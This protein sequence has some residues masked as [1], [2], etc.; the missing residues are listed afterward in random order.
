MAATIE[1]LRLADAAPVTLAGAIAVWRR[2]DQERVPE[3]P[4]TP[5]AVYARQLTAPP[6]HFRLMAWTA[7]EAG[8]V[9]GIAYLQLPDVDN[10]E[11]GWAGV[12]VAPEARRRGIGRHLLRRVAERASAE[13]RSTLVG[14][15]SD[16]VPSGAAF[17]GAVGATPG[18]EAHTNQLDLRTIESAGVR[19]R[20]DESKVKAAGYRVAWVDWANADDA[21]IAQVAQ[22]YEAINDMPKGDIAFEDER[23]DV[24]RTRERAAHFA[25]MGLEVWTAIAI[26]DA[27]GA[28]VGF[29]E[30]NLTPEVP[31][32]VQQ[33]G[34]A[35][36]PAHR[37]HGLGM[38]L[39]ATALERLLRERPAARF[40][41]TGNADV[42]EAML[43]INTELGFRPAWSTAL[44]QADVTTLLEVKT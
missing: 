20:I 26:H 5:D 19:R 3:D 8:T 43:R 9:V 7:S 39:K 21:V 37:G 16:R 42:N 34:T 15:V 40:I 31:E 12:L 14:S 33:Q 36:T 35:V 11:M 44:W 32:I 2:T 27:T 29:T 41:R 4:V 22:A 18:L 23:W 13:R 17:A 24:R 6:S 25:Q 1:E 30:L 28:G 10:L 38:L